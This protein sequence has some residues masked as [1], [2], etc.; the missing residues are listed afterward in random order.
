M[1][2]QGELIF[3]ERKLLGHIAVML[4]TLRVMTLK[5]MMRLAPRIPPL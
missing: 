4:L 1:W 5:A 3:Y 2:L